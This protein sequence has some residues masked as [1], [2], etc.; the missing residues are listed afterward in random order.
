[1]PFAGKKRACF[2]SKGLEGKG[3][4][5]ANEDPKNGEFLV[6]TSLCPGSRGDEGEPLTC[7]PAFPPGR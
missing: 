5:L 3:S 6:L 2:S 1:M 4:C 7:A